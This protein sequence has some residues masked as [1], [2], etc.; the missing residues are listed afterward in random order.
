MLDGSGNS[1]SCISTVTVKDT[2]PP[3]IGSIMANPAA[4][5]PPNHKMVP[6]SVTVAATDVCDPAPVCRIA[7]VTS[8]EAITAADWSIT[9]P[10]SVNLAASRQGSGSGRVYMIA[11]RCTDASGN[12][13]TSSVNVTVPHDA[14]H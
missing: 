12:A 14:G 11:L 5:W 4:I 1:G 3:V 9:G 2:T 8:N 13:A 10:L 6:V 7:G